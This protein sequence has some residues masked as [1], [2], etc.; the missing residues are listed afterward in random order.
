MLHLLPIR[1]MLIAFAGVVA[2]LIVMALYAG[3]IVGDDPTEVMLQVFRWAPPL[4]V[5]AIVVTYAAWRWIPPV[6][7]AIF[8]YLGGV[9]SGKVCFDNENGE[10]DS[11]EVKLTAKHTLFRIKLLLESDE[12]RS[13]TLAVQAEKVDGFDLYQLYYVYLSER[14]EGIK[15][16]GTKYRGLAIVRYDQG[17]PPKLQGN[18][19]TET[20]RSGT[21]HLERTCSTRWWKLWR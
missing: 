13:L 12:T 9:W 14:K 16:A 19:F 2:M 3:W 20:R 4:A 1:L 17:N 11:R 5:G 8:P 15:N 7:L 18:Y 21:L 6:Q 10:S